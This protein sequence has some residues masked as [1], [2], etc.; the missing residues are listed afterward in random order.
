[1]KKFKEKVIEQ[2]YHSFREYVVVKG[3]MGM[4][5]SKAMVDPLW[6][7][8]EKS[9]EWRIDNVFKK[10]SLSNFINEVEEAQRIVGKDYA[11]NQDKWHRLVEGIED[12][13]D[14]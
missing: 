13:N 9:L 12:E 8:F 10:S 14:N 7:G 6:E 2:I 3:I 4:K 5:A 1:M 11:I